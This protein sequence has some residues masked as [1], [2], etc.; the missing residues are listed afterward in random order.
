MDNSTKESIEVVI[1]LI[2]GI[3]VLGLISFVTIGQKLL[4]IFER[5][6]G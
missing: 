2:C 3:A 1:E 4:P 6:I 5:L